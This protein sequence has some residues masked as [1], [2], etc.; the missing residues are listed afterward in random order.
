MADAL[1]QAVRQQ[2]GLG[3]LLPLGTALDGAWLT[4]HAATG[5]LRTAA[6]T[7]PGTRVTALRIDL[8]D[9]TDAARPA[10]P[11]PPTALAPGPLRVSGEFLATADQ[12]LPTS[13]ERLRAVLHT[14]AVDRLGLAV[15]TVDLRVTGLLD[16]SDTEPPGTTGAPGSVDVLDELNDMDDAAEAVGTFLAGDVD[17]LPDGK[18]VAGSILLD[19]AT[20]AAGSAQAAGRA[21]AG[22]TGPHPP[23]PE[24]PRAGRRPAAAV[25]AEE[26][27]AAAVAAV[28]GVAGLA[29]AL[30]GLTRAVRIETGPRE[31]YGAAD[32]GGGDDDRS[33]RNSG[34]HRAGAGA[35]SAPSGSAT[36]AATRRHVQAQVAVAAGHR[37]ITVARAVREAARAAL[38]PDSAER[39][40]VTVAVLVTAVD[41]AAPQPT[42]RPADPTTN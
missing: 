21:S 17:D 41:Q 23:E 2:L 14:T 33:D 18:E 40:G 34:G 36:V 4:E 29:P 30:G 5:A 3:R 16:G 13:A 20:G 35:P 26:R 28:P 6:A 27:V 24:P 31:Q 19:G 22:P 9:P 37:P 32:P 39:A 11:A 1:T 15:T 8:A 12:P 10:V 25:P 7:V 42:D 38:A